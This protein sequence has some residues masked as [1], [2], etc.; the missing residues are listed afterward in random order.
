MVDQA[1][2]APPD[3]EPAV[4][5]GERPPALGAAAVLTYAASIAVGVLSLGNVLIMA[6]ALGPEGRGE[7]VL[8][9]TL[10]TLSA[11]AFAL[12]VQESNANLAASEPATRP[13]L[14][15]NSVAFALVLG[16]LGAV[17]VV[18][19]VALI[20]QLAV[21][22]DRTLVVVA[23]CSLPVLML[24][25]SLLYLV[26]ADYRFTLANVATLL[27]PAANLAVNGLLAALGAL[28]VGSA[29]ATWIASQAAATALLAWFVARGPSGF[30][31]PRADIAGR[32]VRFGLQTHVSGLLASGNY[33]IDHLFV[34]SLAGT[35]EL[36]LYS[37]AATWVETLFLLPTALAVVLRPDL[38]RADRDQAGRQA[39]AVAR[40][41]LLVTLPLAIGMAL[42]AP[43]LCVTMFGDEFA[44]SVS[45]LRLLVPGVVGILLIKTLG[46]ALI[47]Q[48]RPLL[49]ALAVA[50][51]FAVTVI[52]DVLLIPP[53][54]G[55]GAAIASTL[56]YTAGG[57]AATAIFL[58]TLG[59]RPA[60]LIPRRADLTLLLELA[61]RGL[62]VARRGRRA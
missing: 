20:P 5:A 57:V 31:R 11:F 21:G 32:S 12:S 19:L 56:A 18:S 6:R 8:L 43:I 23:A 39:A 41:A 29:V 36:G 16:A 17:A 50:A 62:A 34:A 59:R 49:E 15:G 46:G 37:I 27:V 47:A 35:R 40:V 42:A 24:Q 28:S 4:P 52:C 44:G 38:V 55:D 14:A 10:A 54:G 60:E 1:P 25:T 2:A 22:I 3:R 58:R 7:V 51:A 61:G 9:T 45:Q 13:T 48:G 26:R 30:S 53:F 33:R